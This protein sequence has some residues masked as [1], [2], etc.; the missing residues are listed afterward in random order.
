MK[1]YPKA[2]VYCGSVGPL[3]EEHV[4][5]DWILSGGYLPRIANKHGLSLNTITPAGT[6]NISHHVTKA[7][8]P[9]GLKLKVVCSTCNNVWMSDLQTGAKKH[10]VHL[11][12]GDKPWILGVPAKEAIASWATMVAMTSEFQSRDP[13]TYVIAQQDRDHL[14]IHGKPPHSW[15][16]WMGTY[17]GSG[18]WNGWWE[19][20]SAPIFMSHER[21]EAEEAAA[22]GVPQPNTQSTTFVV[23]RVYFHVMSGRFHEDIAAWNWHNAQRARTLLTQI[24]PAPPGITRWPLQ[25]LTDRDADQFTEA[26]FNMYPDLVKAKTS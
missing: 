8:D 2:C 23:G 1:Q 12:P 26:F 22:G 15:R 18:R 13:Q 9:L 10:L 16:A 5:G 7:G 11:F 21:L 20:H 19:R 17:S 25:T 3:T 6:P 24:W 4:Y 14:R